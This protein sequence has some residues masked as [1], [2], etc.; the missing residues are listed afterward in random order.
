MSVLLS[1]LL[2]TVAA[3]P[4]KTDASVHETRL[5]IARYGQ[6]VIKKR[7]KLAA[8]AILNGI[9]NGD[10]QDRYPQLIDGSCLAPRPNEVVK[11]SFTG[12]HFR[13][14]LADSLVRHQLAAVPAPTLDA[15]PR[16]THHE[17]S[18]PLRTDK[19]GKPLSA[20][21]YQQ[22]LENFKE[23]QAFAY[24]SRYGECV[25]RVDPAAARALLLTEPTSAAEAAQFA[26]MSASLGNCLPAG[27][28]LAFGK[29]ALRGTIAINY[30][31]LAKAAALPVQPGRPAQ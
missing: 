11:V 12:D 28:T 30:Y 27:Q 16:L 6:C 13:Y 17:P 15:V 3:Q 26:A 18:E 10:L 21:K 14:A 9:G 31:R 1:A 29:L 4:G 2:L 8:E 22:A 5:L 25:V 23:D 24:L 20:K 7:E 19:K